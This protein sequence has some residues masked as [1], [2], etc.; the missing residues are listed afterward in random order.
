L[1][2]PPPYSSGHVGAEQ[3]LLAGL[4]P[5]RAVDDAR[6]LPLVVERGDLLRG[7][8]ADGVAEGVVLGVVEGR[9]AWG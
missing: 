7:E 3:A 5:H 6:L 9:S 2:P 8:R 4:Q 1:T